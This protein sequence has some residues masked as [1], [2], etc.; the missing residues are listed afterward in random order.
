[1]N[2][3]AEIGSSVFQLR[4]TDED[5]RPVAGSAAAVA[6]HRG[7]TALVTSYSLVKA[8]TISPGPGIELV[9]GDRTIPATL[10]SWDKDRDLALV[11]VEVELPRLTLSDDDEQTA[12]VG[13]GVFA[14]SGSGGQGATASPGTVLDRSEAGLQH[15]AVIGTVFEGGPL[16]DADGKLVGVASTAYRPLGIDGGDVSFAPD[17]A[18]LCSRLLNCAD[19]ISPGTSDAEGG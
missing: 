1:M 13:S 2:L 5:G 8:A 12:I 7:G 14:I 3:P 19:P 11:V 17:L 6:E 4:T 9:K 16:V 10:W 15:T 18:G